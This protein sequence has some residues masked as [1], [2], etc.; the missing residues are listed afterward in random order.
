MDGRERKDVRP[1]PTV[2]IVMKQDQQ[3]GRLTRGLVKD[4]LCS[5]RSDG[6]HI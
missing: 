6:I 3:T 4:V 1:G 2:D 5:G